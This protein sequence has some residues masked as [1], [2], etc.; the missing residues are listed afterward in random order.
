MSLS[1]NTHL[2]N[3]EAPGPSPDEDE[4]KKEVDAQNERE[5]EQA[6]EA[7]KNLVPESEEAVDDLKNRWSPSP[8]KDGEIAAFPDTPDVEADEH[9]EKAA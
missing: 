4:M 2:Y 3:G 9:D 5:H 6:K 1:H 7:S 8:E